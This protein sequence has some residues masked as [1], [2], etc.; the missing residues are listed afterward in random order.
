MAFRFTL[1]A[2]LVYRESLEHRE[3]IALE[4]I[5]QGI[6]RTEAQIL[7]VE[8]WRTTAAQQR[9]A[10][11]ARGIHSVQLQ[12]AYEHELALER[13]RDLLRDK[14]REL[15]SRLQQQLKTY[16]LARQKRRVL[17]ELRGHQFETYTRDQ[18]RRQQYLLDELFLARRRRS[19]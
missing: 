12:Q 9:A 16:E 1:A 6:T 18:A 5:Q 4:Q 7:Q 11:L 10:E 13:Q 19:Q 8:E 2:V 3:Y 15:K 14:L 17:D